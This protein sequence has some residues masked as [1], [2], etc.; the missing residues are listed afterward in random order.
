MHIVVT[1]YIVIFIVCV[2]G[3]FYENNYNYD[4]LASP[5]KRWNDALVLLVIILLIY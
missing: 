2:L 3:C 4:W 5:E 1:R